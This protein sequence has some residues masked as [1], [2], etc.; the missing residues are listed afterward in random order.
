[1]ECW[2]IGMVEYWDFT[3]P[4]IYPVRNDGLLEFLMGFT[5]LRFT[6]LNPKTPLKTENE[7]RIYILHENL[8]FPIG[9]SNG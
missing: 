3:H 8:S 2:N 7:A 9:C 5:P 1:M 4:S 6:C